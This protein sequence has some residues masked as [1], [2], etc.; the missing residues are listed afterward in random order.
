MSQESIDVLK[1]MGS[2][3]GA[4]AGTIALLWRLYDEIIRS[5]LGISIEVSEPAN[6]WIT[7]LTT[8]ENK[9]LRPKPV[10]FAMLLVGPEK[11]SPVQTANVLMAALKPS[12][13]AKYTN[14]LEQL[15]ELLREAIIAPNRAAIPLDFYYSENVDIA[16]ETLTYRASVPLS[17]FECN[18]PISVRFYLFASNRLHRSTHDAFVI[19]IAASNKPLSAPV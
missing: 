1:I 18:S 2:I 6:G 11:E 16:D 9:S 5:F 17:T 3:V 8:V 7:V 14:D 12:W 10:N 19:P 4:L 13:R 15:K